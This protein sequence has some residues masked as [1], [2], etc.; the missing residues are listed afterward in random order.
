MIN[1]TIKPGR[2]IPKGSPKQSKCPLELANVCCFQVSQTS[3][4]DE[5]Y[6]DEPA[7]EP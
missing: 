1:S 3:E 7:D 5:M 4:D 6:V 2:V